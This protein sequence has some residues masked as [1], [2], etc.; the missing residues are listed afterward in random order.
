[1]MSG[2]SPADRPGTPA[3]AAAHL[4]SSSPL[5]GAGLVVAAPGS[6]VQWGIPTQAV[7]P[8]NSAQALLV[9]A[10]VDHNNAITALT[11]APTSVA[12]DLF[13]GSVPEDYICGTCRRVPLKPVNPK[14]CG[15]IW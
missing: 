2:T 15:Q 8:A 7:A 5:A 13:V 6:S 12:T 4:S 1:L 3:A 9:A 11:G 14:C 10:G